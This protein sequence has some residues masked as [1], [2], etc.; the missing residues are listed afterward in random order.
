[1]WLLS[2]K[3]YHNYQNNKT[4]VLK[5]CFSLDDVTFYKKMNNPRFYNGNLSMKIKYGNLKYYDLR[6]QREREAFSV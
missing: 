2:M 4:H 6:S 5:F 1:M 3:N